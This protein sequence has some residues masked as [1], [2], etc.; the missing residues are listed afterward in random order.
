MV[1]SMA[2]ERRWSSGASECEANGQGTHRLYRLR[3]SRWR[4]D[5]GR[6]AAGA[7][8]IRRGGKVCLMQG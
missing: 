3:T 6:R 7:D 1:S 4:P 8:M 2:L 5:I